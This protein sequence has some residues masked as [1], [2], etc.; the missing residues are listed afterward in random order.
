MLIWLPVFF[1]FF[2]KIIK[3]LSLVQAKLHTQLF[4]HKKHVAMTEMT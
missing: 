1:Y 2:C 4:N 3:A